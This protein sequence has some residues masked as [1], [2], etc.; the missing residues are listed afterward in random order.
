MAAMIERLFPLIAQWG[1]WILGGLLLLALVGIWRLGRG[2]RFLL[3]AG[4]A[5]R[6]GS[7]FLVLLTVVTGLGLFVLLG[8]ARPIM[9]EVRRIHGA[10]GETAPELAFQR[11]ADNSPQ[12]LSNLRGQ[13]V[14]VNLWATWC[15]PCRKEMPELN[16]LQKEYGGQGLVVVTVSDEERDLLRKFAAEH[17]FETVNAYA[18]DLGWF[19]VPGRPLSVVIDRQGVV[20]EVIIGGR[21]YGELEAMVQPY[22]IPS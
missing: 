22:L 12:R 4:W 6:L 9:A 17:P 14:L 21:G 7:A 19:D 11:V 20:R 1:I 15:P 16:R 18:A 10:I 8:P 5:G 2:R 13:V 3:P